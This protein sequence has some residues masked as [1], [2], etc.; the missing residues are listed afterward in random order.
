L[1]LLSMPRCSIGSDSAD[2]THTEVGTSTQALYDEAKK[3]GSVLKVEC[4]LWVISGHRSAHRV[5]LLCA[6]CGRLP[7]G[8]G[9]S[10]VM[11]GWSVLPC[12]RPVDAALSHGRWP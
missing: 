12:V 10:E 2:F 3:D 9:F 11:H 5:G 1:D 6:M 8:K 4:L 7:V